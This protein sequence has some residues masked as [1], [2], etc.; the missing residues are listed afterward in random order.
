MIKISYIDKNVLPVS[1]KIISCST[2]T[3]TH[4][5]L[6]K[7]KFRLSKPLFYYTRQMMLIWWWS[8]II[9]QTNIFIRDS[10]VRSKGLFI[11]FFQLATILR[12]SLRFSMDEWIT[13][14]RY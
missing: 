12:V 11:N 1:Q 7:V 10:S 5:Y 3:P 14:S 9:S 4:L 2:R 6:A 8:N 13:C